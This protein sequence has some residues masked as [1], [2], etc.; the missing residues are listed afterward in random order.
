MR[1]YNFHAVGWAFETAEGLALPPSESVV[2]YA[3]AAFANA[4]PATPSLNGMAWPSSDALM[5]KTRLSRRSLQTATAALV[6]RGLLIPAG[7]VGKTAKVPRYQLAGFLTDWNAAAPLF[8][9]GEYRP[10]AAP[11]ERRQKAAQQLPPGVSQPGF[12]AVEETG[13]DPEQY[14]PPPETADYPGGRRPLTARE[15]QFD[16]WGRREAA[17]QDGKDDEGFYRDKPAGPANAEPPPPT[18]PAADERVKVRRVMSG[19]YPP[20]WNRR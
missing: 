8:S 6:R 11:Q 9:D 19:E 14:S 13:I 4:D 18:T 16:R 20:D 7:R 1:C 3:Y 12:L 17:K 10:A 2:L 5:S 15:R